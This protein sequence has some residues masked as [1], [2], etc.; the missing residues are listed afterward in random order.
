[1][2]YVVQVKNSTAEVTCLIKIDL[3]NLK[4]MAGW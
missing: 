2:L 1:L 3:L 4:L